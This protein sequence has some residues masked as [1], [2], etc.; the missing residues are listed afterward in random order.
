MPADE[1]VVRELAYRLWE[2]RGRPEGS[3]EQDWVDAER[4]LAAGEPPDAA[5]GLPDDEDPLAA[6]RP[7]KTLTDA[8]AGDEPTAAVDALDGALPN[9][10][11]S[12]ALAGK[13]PA[14]RRRSRQSGDSTSAD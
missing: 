8:T 7:A 3:A 9:G 13:R 1:K 11:S 12:A 2:S 14:G 4:Q 5:A 6:T 10:A